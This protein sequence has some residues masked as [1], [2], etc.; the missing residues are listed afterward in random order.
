MSNIGSRLSG[1]GRGILNFAKDNPADAA[2]IARTGLEAY[3]AHQEGQFIDREQQR[4]NQRQENMDPVV[5]E[6]LR[7]IMNPESL[8][9]AP[10]V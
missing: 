8:A 9:A 6:L 7:R 4:R 2:D 5:A 1:A 3:G 10:R